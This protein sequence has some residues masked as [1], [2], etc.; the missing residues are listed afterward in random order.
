VYI[1]DHVR[2]CCEQ[3]VPTS[4]SRNQTIYYGLSEQYRSAAARADESN[5][6][7]FHLCA[8]QFPSGYKGNDDLLQAPAALVR[9]APQHAWK[10]DIAGWGDFS[11]FQKMAAD[12][13]VADRVNWLGMQDT[14]Q[15]ADLLQ[16]SACLVYPSKFEGFGL[17][18]IEAFASRCP[19]VAV[20]CTAI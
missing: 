16:R 5:R 1:S 4:R 15:V 2:D 7:P 17:P 19:A 3:L 20:D 8:L 11:A 6:R 10:L 14:A 9:L 13:G 18:L 12:L